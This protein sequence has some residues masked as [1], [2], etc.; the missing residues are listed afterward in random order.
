MSR[1]VLLLALLLAG[2]HAHTGVGVATGTPGMVPEA[3]ASVHVHAGP[4][5]GTLIGI[6]IIAASIRDERA[7]PGRAVPEL[8][9]TRRVQ[10]Q[11]C[12]KPIEDPSA[13]LRCR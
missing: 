4:A 12:S 10:E 1:I 8:D 11:D 2:C 3:S 5:I 9:P 6:G 7:Y 13:N